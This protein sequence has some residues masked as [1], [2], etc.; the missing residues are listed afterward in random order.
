MELIGVFNTKSVVTK[1][2]PIMLAT[3]QNPEYWVDAYAID[4]TP[5][6][7]KLPGGIQAGDYVDVE[8]E[9][10]FTNNT[11]ETG[12]VTALTMT[13]TAPG[14]DN[15][16][17]GAGVFLSNPQV[18]DADKSII[19]HQVRTPNGGFTVTDAT[20]AAMACI[21]FR[22]A[23]QSTAAMSTAVPIIIESGYGQMTVK[24]YR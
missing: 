18:M 17:D 19:H 14:S 9:C 7:V 6:A 21:R 3:A 2:V 24:V 12:I 8:A 13:P 23:A 4:L 22:V 20:Y 16:F 1:S 10:E 15:P 5:D 11:V